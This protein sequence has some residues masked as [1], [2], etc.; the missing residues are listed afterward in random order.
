MQ[1]ETIGDAYLVVSGLP[2]RSGKHVKE[3]AD[4]SLEVLNATKQFVIPHMPRLVH[5]SNAHK[6]AR[7][8]I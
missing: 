8:L 2:T 1:V 4:M 7:A 5:A 3:I 6:H